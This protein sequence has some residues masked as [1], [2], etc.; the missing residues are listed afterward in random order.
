MQRKQGLH[1][2]GIVEAARREMENRISDAATAAASSGLADGTDIG[3]MYSN[4][5]STLHQQK[6]EAE[7]AITMKRLFLQ[8]VEPHYGEGRITS[9]HNM[10]GK[11]EEPW[12]TVKGRYAPRIGDRTV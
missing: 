7:K 6:I 4:S 12:T 2:E 3:D 1:R 10:K 11:L 8:K 9:T 5:L